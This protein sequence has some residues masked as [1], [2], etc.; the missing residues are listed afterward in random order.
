M[1]IM[2]V[3]TAVDVGFEGNTVAI[4]QVLLAIIRLSTLNY[5]PP[6]FHPYI[7][8]PELVN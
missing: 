7:Y 1:V 8:H 4:R 2:K 5:N 3:P 6:N